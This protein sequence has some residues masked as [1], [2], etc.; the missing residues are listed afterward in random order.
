MEKTIRINDEAWRAL[1]IAGL[2]DYYQAAFK[3]SRK[4]GV[5]HWLVLHRI[6]DLRAAG[7]EGTRQQRLAEGLLAD[8][9]TTIVYRQHAQEIPLTTD[10]LGLSE[11][12]RDL[13]GSLEQGV[14]LWRAGGRS[15]E[16]RHLLSDLEWDLIDTDQAMG[17]RRDQPPT[18]ATAMSRNDDDHVWPLARPVRGA[19][20]GAG[21]RDHRQRARRSAR[22][23]SADLDRTVA[24]G[25]APRPPR[26][27]TCPTRRSRGRPPTA[28]TSP[29]PAELHAV[30][31]ISPIA[32]GWPPSARLARWPDA[33][34][35]SA[36]RKRSARWATR[37]DLAELRV[38][39]PEP[40]RITLGHHRRALIA[41]EERVSVMVVGPTQ[42]GKTTGLVVPAMR[43]W[44]GPV[45]A[46][47]IKA[48]VLLHTLAARSELGEA[49]V[50]DPT[51][52]TSLAHA[53]WSPLT[54]ST[55]LDRRA[56]HRRRAARRRRPPRRP[57]RRRRVLAPRRRALPRR[58]PLRRHQGHRT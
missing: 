11:T 40:G 52:A 10:A 31:P 57:L 9:S 24:G 33:L 29:A 58:P 39:R 5:Q 12:E 6:S 55:Y 2:G 27:R 49:R 30:L 44:H 25:H 15:F 3:L 50:F 37:S 45:L 38:R 7:D 1:P 17:P 35:D 56:A 13:I 8:A 47:S 28:A 42:S 43:E 20:R 21:V 41:A 46:T 26:S 16:I 36:P 51:E 18:G 32:V 22:A 19:R 14:A 54:A 4:T 34:R 53:V 23:R 48:D